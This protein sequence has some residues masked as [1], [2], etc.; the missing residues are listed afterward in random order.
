MIDQHA[1]S[2]AFALDG[3]L[4]VAHGLDPAA[5]RSVSILSGLF[6][7]LKLLLVNEIPAGCSVRLDFTDLI[8]DLHVDERGDVSVNNC[9]RGP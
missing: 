7:L 9:P 6:L 4:T 1:G 5:W 2:L 3:Q 8:V